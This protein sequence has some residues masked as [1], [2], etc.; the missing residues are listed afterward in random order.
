MTI[1]E[2]EDEAPATNASL[3]KSGGTKAG[4]ASPTAVSPS[5]RGGVVKIMED[6]DTTANNQA[7]VE[8]MKNSDKTTMLESLWAQQ[9]QLNLYKAEIASREKVLKTLQ[10]KA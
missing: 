2:G 9:Q 10:G 6:H 3:G 5:G 4:L 1:V 8:S 7:S